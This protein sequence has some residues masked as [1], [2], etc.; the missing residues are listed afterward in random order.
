MIRFSRRDTRSVGFDG[1]FNRDI[2][3]DLELFGQPWFSKHN[4]QGRAIQVLSMNRLNCQDCRLRS[5]KPNMGK[6]TKFPG[7]RFPQ[8]NGFNTATG[9]TELF[10]VRVHNGRGQIAYVHGVAIPTTGR[11]RSR[12]RRRGQGR[13][14]QHPFFKQR[15]VKGKGHFGANFIFKTQAGSP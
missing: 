6:M 15:L 1:L 10:Q 11:R 4:R 13:D 7:P 5:L 12:G 3:D 2:H 9:G 14:V 8:P